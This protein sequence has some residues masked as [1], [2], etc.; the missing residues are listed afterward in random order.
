[1]GSWNGT[2]ALTHLPLGQ[3]APVVAYVLHLTGIG[4][5]GTPGGGFIRANDMAHPVGPALLGE[6]NGYGGIGHLH[7]PALAWWRARLVEMEPELMTAQAEA[8][9]SETVGSLEAWLN[10]GIAEGCVYQGP[11]SKRGSDD[12]E[13]STQFG[14]MLVHAGAH[15]CFMARAQAPEDWMLDDG[16]ANPVVLYLEKL[17]AVEVSMAAV[18]AAEAKGKTKDAAYTRLRSTVFR[19]FDTMGAFRSRST[20]VLGSVFRYARA[21]NDEALLTEVANTFIFDIGLEIA[22]K[23]WNRQ[24]GVGSGNS[25]FGLQLAL[26]QFVV[27]QAAP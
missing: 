17:R 11:A 19:A 7:G 13:P 18:A 10:D 26:A 1:M 24:C 20:E 12:Y 14:L 21:H 5:H 15:A 27:D 2:C 3:G 6:Y 4:R 16:C 23:S 22:R 9:E 8:P 25:D